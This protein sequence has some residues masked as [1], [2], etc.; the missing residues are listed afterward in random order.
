MRHLVPLLLLLIL[1]GSSVADDWSVKRSAFD[2]RIVARYKAMLSHRPN[3]GYALGKLVALYRKHRSLGALV[4]EYRALA[5]GNPKSFAYQVILGHLQRSAGNTEQA[6]LHYERAAALNPKS[7]T[8]PAALAAMYRKLGRTQD[9]QKSYE[10]TL[11]MAQ[12]ARDRKRYL[13]ALATLSLATNDMAAAR[14]YFDR[15]VALEPKNIL[16]RIELAQALAKSGHEAEAIAQYQTIL[17]STSDSSQKADVLKEIGGLL[18]KQGKVEQAVATYRKA[19]GLTAAGHWLRRDLTERVIAI[20]R[21]RE[22][23]K[24]LIEHYEQTWKRRGQFE[25][26]VL[27]RLYDETGDEARALKSYN[28]ALKAAPH[29]VDTRVRLIGLLERSGQDKEVIAEYRKLARIAPGEPRY[30][31]ELAKRLY[32][33]GAQKEAFLILDR[34]GQRFPGDASVHSALADLYARWGEQKRA[35]RAAQILVRIEPQDPSHL[36]N[37]GEQLY[38]QG[39]KRKAIE[40][41]RRL[42]QVVPKRHAA[43]ARLAEIFGQHDMTREAIDLLTR[44]IKLKPKH[45]PYHRALA[46]LLER[47]RH[48]IKALQSWDQVLQLA[49][50]EGLRAASREARTRIIDI[51]HRSYQLRGRINVYRMDFEGPA[52]NVDAGF[53]LAEAY[54]KLGDVEHAAEVYR[55]VLKIDDKNLEALTALESVYRR[56]RKLQQA[57]ELLKQLA[58]LQPQLARDYYQRMADLLLQLYDDKQALVY[59]HKALAMGSG[60]AKSYQQLGELYEKQ[61]DYENAMKAY[62]QAIKLAPSRFQVHF[63]LARMLSQQ[64]RYAQ[65]EKLYRQVI[66]T[67]QP[68]ELIQ[69]AFRIGVELSGYLNQLEQLEKE[70]VPLSVMSTNAQVYRRLLVQIYRRRVPMLID[71]ARQGSSATRQSALDE[72]KR[73]GIR[74]LAPLLEDLSGATTGRGELVRMLGYLQNPNAVVPLLRIASKEP[75]ESVVTIRGTSGYYPYRYSSLNNKKLMRAVNLRVEATVA[76]GR[77]ADE[78]AVPGLVLLLSSREGPLRDAAAWAL[79]RVDSRAGTKALFQALG[80]PR[81]TAQMMACAGLGLNGGPSMRPVLEEVML[82]HSRDERV[83]ASCAWGL[84]ASG[85]GRGTTSLSTMLESGDME[86]QR[87]AAW[88]LGATG[89]TQALP[90]LVRALW[91]KQRNVRR[92]VLWSI[93]QIATGAP[94][95]PVRQTPDVVMQDGTVDGHRFL[96]ALTASVAE[97]EGAGLARAL[98]RVV[99]G[100]REALVQGLIAALGRHRDVA[101]RVLVDLDSDPRQLSLGPLTAHRDR[102]TAGERVQLD[103]SVHAVCLP[104]AP[105]IARLIGHRDPLVRERAISLYAKLAPQDVAL[106][107]RRGLTD[108]SSSVRVK[109]LSGVRLA[110]QRGRFSLTEATSI[111]GT[112]LGR[113][114][115]QERETAAV[116]AGEIARPELAPL[117]VR[118]LTDPNG[119]VRQAAARALSHVGTKPGIA[120]LRRALDDD[121]PHVRAAACWSLGQLRVMAARPQV[122]ARTT[123]PSRMVQTAA[124]MALRRL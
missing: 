78:R 52:R 103:R 9:A 50:A 63:A 62:R 77:I 71:Q 96:A 113:Q 29:A 119:F 116:V 75:E 18:H 36:I 42:L 88:S 24:S 83:R 33:S 1:V 23:L 53:M 104:L 115:F 14:R 108:P 72:L 12:S 58:L 93:A 37:L 67:A 17:N 107:I 3:D 48:V 57:V 39:N 35:M 19:M 94:I 79:S 76:V 81:A 49:K 5:Q 82:D 87:C 89:Q 27:G 28:A 16:L 51:L 122:Q 7:P 21:Q 95:T 60:D 15:L 102:L 69:K 45:V 56:Q 2:P 97:L 91:S 38:L 6:V 4:A 34:C 114:Q 8:V 100:E 26:E 40:T 99:T 70:I 118:A 121:V 65:A 124:R 43:L 106:Q 10:Q 80:D 105:H 44:A 66:T 98:Y 54:L 20:Y 68:P 110:L 111:L 25:H 117:L 59:A 41:W 84:G 46:L 61:E 86:L 11:T 90:A 120:A 32:R 101:L 47:K 13:K 123:D 64:G 22:N 73:I 109:A 85:Q 30:Q 92:V 74:G 55:S 31:L 112:S